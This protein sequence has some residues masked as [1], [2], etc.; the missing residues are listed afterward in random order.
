MAGGS[1]AGIHHDG[2][3]G[4][5]DDDLQEVLHP[6]SLVGADGSCQRHHGS[7]SSLFQMLAEC[8]VGL[9]IR[10]YDKAQFDQ[11]L[12]GLEGLDRVGEEV[13]WVGVN[14]QF[15]PVGAEGLACHLGSKDSL[16]GCAYTAGVGKQLDALVLG[17][18]GE[19]VIVPVL[20]FD[21]LHGHRHH[22]GARCLDGLCHQ[23]VVVEF[24]CSQEK[25]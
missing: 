2:H 1:N 21:A 6:Q 12:R 11:L 23:T 5:F 24:T 7:G 16:F 14:L 15:E 9:T 25:A 4:L 8:G 3:G 22:L 18:V 20:Q 13:A 19:Q 17:D 10:Q